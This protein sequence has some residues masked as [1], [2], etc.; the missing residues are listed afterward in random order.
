M[1]KH[2]KMGGRGLIAR[3]TKLVIRELVLLAT[4]PPPPLEQGERLETDL[5]AK[6]SD[7]ISHAYLIK[8]PS[9]PY[10]KGFRECWIC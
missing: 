1:G 6:G 3:G 10:P 4:P 2:L 8:P 5:I 7:L 9:K